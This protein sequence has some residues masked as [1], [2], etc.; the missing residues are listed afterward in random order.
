ML[1]SHVSRLPIIL[2]LF[3]CLQGVSFAARTTVS[4]VLR[5]ADGTTCSGSLN[6]SWQTFTST[7]GQLIYGGS[8]SSRVIAGVVNVSLEPFTSYS[9]A[10]QLAPPGCTPS[11]EYWS[12]PTSATP[13]NIAAVRTLYPP[14][15]PAQVSLTSLSQSG[16]TN[17]QCVL[18]STSFGYWTPGACGGGGTITS[19]NFNCGI[20]STQTPITTSAT[21]GVYGVCSS[22]ANAGTTGTTVN[23][24]AKLTGAPSAAVITAT[25]DTGGAIGVVIAGA[26]TTGSATIQMV[27][28]IPCT[29]DNSTTAGDYVQLSSSV[30]GD[31][32]DAGATFPASGQVIGQVVTSSSAGVLYVDTALGQANT[33]GGSPPLGSNGDVQM[34]NGSALA[35]SHINDTGT[36]LNMT[37]PVCIGAGSCADTSGLSGTAS[38]L[39]FK[40]GTSSGTMSADG[41]LRDISNVPTWIDNSGSRALLLA[42]CSSCVS[43]ATM[44]T[45][46]LPVTNLNSGTSASSSTFWRGDGTWATAA[47]TNFSNITTIV[48]DLLFTDAT[49]DLGKT[50]ATRPRD[51]FFSRNLVFGGTLNGVST[52]TL[53]YLDATSSIQTQFNA[54]AATDLSNIGTVVHDLVFTDATYDIGKSGATR[55]RNIFASGTGTF[56]G[57]LSSPS[58]QGAGSAASLISMPANGTPATPVANSWGFTANAA[59]ATSWYETSPN[60]VPTANQIKL[61]PAPTSNVSAWSWLTLQIAGDCTS[62]AGSLTIACSKINGTSFAGT[63]GDLVGFGASNIPAD[64]GIVAANVVKA[65]SPGAGIAHFAGGTQTATSSAVDL[66]GADVTGNLPVTKLN[67]GTSASSSTFWRGDGT[68]AAAGGGGSG[69]VTSVSVTTVNGVSG[70]VATATTTPAISLTLGAIT[71]SSVAST[72][73]VSGTSLS[74]GSSPP[75]VTGNG[76]M[77]LGE[78][79]GQGCAANADCLIA[80][81]ATH[82]VLLSN[83]NATAVPVVVGPASATSGHYAAFSGTSGGIISDGGVVPTVTGGTCTN[84]AVTAIS[85]SA[86]PTCT[87]VTSAYVD[88]SIAKTGTDINTSNQVTVTHLAAALP[89]NQGGTGTTSTLTGLMRGNSS[90]M[91][92][93]ELSGDCTTSGSNAVTCTKINGTSFPTSATIVGSNGSAQPVAATT[94]GSGTTVV[95]AT[96]PTLVTPVLGTPAS[97]NASN[98]TNFPTSLVQAPCATTITTGASAT[99]STC[100]TVNQ[101]A[102]A[103]TAITYTLP[104]ASSG[105]QYCVDNSYNGSAADT[106][107]VELLTSATG[108]Y[109][110]WTDGTLSATGGYGISAGAAR[111][112]ACVYGI[113]STHWMF[114]PHAGTW[115]KH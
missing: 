11:F 79:T 105:A 113:D 17:G 115:T 85:N 71:P 81:S 2:L 30:A 72:G 46:N 1:K 108:Q 28:L 37:E 87:T 31:C 66:S 103:G 84:Q 80:D 38:I 77:G 95:L 21:M 8:I 75:A 47:A 97:G 98:L 82:R 4:D 59:M 62:S 25:T 27:G 40:S 33:S 34:K 55:P 43:L 35:A 53:G 112:G 29:F 90:A 13:V 23:K 64:S 61:Y 12:V 22:I 106:G 19:I 100:F 114:L 92:A 36:Q 9:V 44:V 88:T 89:V 52:T 86:V 91:T 6:V 107:T 41:V 83:N 54:K 60:A 56:G 111:D 102:T 76:I 67:S 45:G 74:A 68:W 57:A 16:A 20:V 63:N 26:G 18:Y 94:T 93:A 73:A 96:S 7:S 10:Y 110:V 51:G 15:P 49:Y 14:V 69:T 3:A 109:L 104:T 5:R 70:S 65:I 24:L 39:G 101:H 48:H 58:W 99:L 50:G 78:T 42:N 32:H